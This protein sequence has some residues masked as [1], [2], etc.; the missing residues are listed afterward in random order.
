MNTPF[1]LSDIQGIEITPSPTLTR[2]SNESIL[3][4]DEIPINFTTIATPLSITGDTLKPEGI[5]DDVNEV[6]NK[7]VNND[8]HK[9]GL[10]KMGLM[11]ALAIGIHNLP[12]GLATF[13][14]ALADP[15]NGV[16]IAVAIALHNIPEG[17]C[18]AMPV[19]YA[20]GSRWKGFLWA[21]LSGLSEPVG[22][23]LGWLV[24]YGNRMSDIAY[25]ALFCTVAGMMVYISIN[26][27]IPTALKYDPH[28]KVVS[29]G[30][31]I[32]MVVISASLLMFTI[33]RGTVVM[34]ARCVI[35][36]LIVAWLRRSNHSVCG[37]SCIAACGE[38][39][40]IWQREYT[41]D[42]AVPGPV[43]SWQGKQCVI[44]E[45]RNLQWFHGCDGAHG[46]CA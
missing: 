2:I 34:K 37:C 39:A 31:V 27:L 42:A 20:T 11:T 4:K 30:V 18:V 8:H 9:F 32:G 7:Y 24:L 43:Y 1:S 41:C 13:A 17:V 5:P 45:L 14:A 40:R 12:E 35:A 22:G 23:L 38:P 15:V 6:V 21:F 29:L 25:G 44:A 28:N 33:Q 19:Y 26:E 3:T 36:A 10:Q 16:A 46:R